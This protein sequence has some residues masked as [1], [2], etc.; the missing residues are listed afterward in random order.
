MLFSTRRQT[1]RAIRDVPRIV[2]D[3]AHSRSYRF[4]R[5]PSSMATGTTT[6]S[7]VRAES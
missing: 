1:Q 7:S 3:Q 6:H 4:Q 2:R 5:M